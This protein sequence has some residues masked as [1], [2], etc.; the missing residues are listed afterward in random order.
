MA[1]HI[2][3]Q[4]TSV[5]QKLEATDSKQ[6]SDL[7]KAFDESFPREGGE[8]TPSAPEPKGGA[9]APEKAPGKPQERAEARSGHHAPVEVAQPEVETKEAAKGEWEAF[10][11]GEV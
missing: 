3:Q 11:Y 2:E 6:L 9:K 5:D 1:E 8:P 7:Q 10:G 4:S